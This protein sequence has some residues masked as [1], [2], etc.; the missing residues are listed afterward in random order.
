MM[1]EEAGENSSS[2]AAEWITRVGEAPSTEAVGSG[3]AF[4]T[5]PSARGAEAGATS[6]VEGVPTMQ[7]GPTYRVVEGA[8]DN[9][10][11]QRNAFAAEGAEASGIASPAD[12]ASERPRVD[13]VE[14]K[15]LSWA[16][17]QF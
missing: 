11:T 5:A 6:L 14:D 8:E 10:A 16:L 7:A 2:S 9:E 15:A 12:A 13:R 17:V 1:D 4:S 3:G